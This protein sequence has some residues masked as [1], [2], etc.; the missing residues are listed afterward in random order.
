MSDSLD[1]LDVIMAKLQSLA[2]LMFQHKVPRAKIRPTLLAVIKEA[3][4]LVLRIS[5][6]NGGIL[7]E[8]LLVVQTAS[9]IL[10]SA[11]EEEAKLEA[12]GCKNA[13]LMN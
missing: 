4:A 10:V 1:Q 11:L 8:S 9:R 2:D 3:D 7:D 5:Q 13:P 12:E 6:Q